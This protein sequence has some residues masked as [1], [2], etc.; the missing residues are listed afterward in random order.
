MWMLVYFSAQARRVESCQ[1]TALSF[2]Q[3]DRRVDSVR[4]EGGPDG[5]QD[6]ERQMKGGMS[7]AEDG[8]RG[9]KWLKEGNGGWR[10]E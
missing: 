6:D 9:R 5:A 4:E 2:S 3:Q 7:E 10:D 8:G 1:D